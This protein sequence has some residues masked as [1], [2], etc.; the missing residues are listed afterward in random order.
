MGVCSGHFAA[1]DSFM[2]SVSF[3]VS[4]RLKLQL[5]RQRTAHNGRLEFAASGK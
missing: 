1:R 3:L 4:R 5:G 2:L